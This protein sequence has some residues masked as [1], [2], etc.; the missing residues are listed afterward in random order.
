M[1]VYVSLEQNENSKF[2]KRVTMLSVKSLTK[3]DRIQT[4]FRLSVN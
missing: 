4:D 3:S 1:P 2:C